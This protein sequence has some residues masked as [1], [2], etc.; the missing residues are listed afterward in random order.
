MM[1]WMHNEGGEFVL[2]PK[3]G[4]SGA[5]VGIPLSDGK[6]VVFRHD[7]FSYSYQPV[8]ESLAMQTWLL[9]EIP[10]Q[11]ALGSAVALPSSLAERERAACLS[12]RCSVPGGCSSYPEFWTS[13]AAGNDC[14]T[15]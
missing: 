9:S 13:L 2:Y 6:M 15:R 12:S 10:E 1:V 4:A 11:R 5:D 8:G 14:H 7:D 3:D